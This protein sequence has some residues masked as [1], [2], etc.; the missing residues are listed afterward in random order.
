M[1]DEKFNQDV[2]NRFGHKLG[3]MQLKG[4]R[5]V[6]PLVATYAQKF[7][8]KN[9]ALIGDAAVGMHPVTAHG[10]NLGLRSADILSDLIKQAI[11]NN[12]IFSSEHLLKK[13]H[14]KQRNI[15]RPLYL[16]T[17]AIVGLFTND[18]PFAKI[19][20]KGVL[21]FG[22]RFPPVKKIITQQLTEEM[23]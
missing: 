10:F 22:N 18:K 16:G 13:Y 6:Y 5:F 9:F 8:A 3:K 11:A 19:L 17:N 21:R 23:K 12:Q 20:R 1:S 14:K 7:Y 15:S 2:A 4:Q